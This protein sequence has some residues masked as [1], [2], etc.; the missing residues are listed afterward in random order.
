MVISNGNG[1]NLYQEGAPF[2]SR[3]IHPDYPELF[4]DFPQTITP[5]P[6]IVSL[7]QI[8]LRPLPDYPSQFISHCRPSIRRHK[9]H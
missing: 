7:P 5:N 3:Q 6:G 1:C 9:G 4:C 2:E 8:R